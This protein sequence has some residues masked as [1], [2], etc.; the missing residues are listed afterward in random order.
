LDTFPRQVTSV[1]AFGV[2]KTNK[3]YCSSLKRKEKFIGIGTCGNAIKEDANKCMGNYIDTLLGVEN[4]KDIKKKVP[5]I[6]W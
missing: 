2:A 3:G 1:L 5:M 6:C 4:E